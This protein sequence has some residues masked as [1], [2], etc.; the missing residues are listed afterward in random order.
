LSCRPAAFFFGAAESGGLFLSEG[1]LWAFPKDFPQS[2]PPPGG[3]DEGLELKMTFMD[4]A[5]EFP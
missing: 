5:R 2:F 3:N 4:S 1:L